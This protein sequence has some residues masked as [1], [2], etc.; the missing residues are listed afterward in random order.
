MSDDQAKEI[1]AIL[2]H[3][4]E[5]QVHILGRLSDISE[6][7]PQIEKAIPD[8]ADSITSMLM[9]LDK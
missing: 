9:I 1:I 7:L 3:I 5:Y 2:T 6:R 4:S 8:A